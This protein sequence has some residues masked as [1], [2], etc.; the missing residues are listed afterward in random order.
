[1]MT[2][3]WALGL[4]VPEDLPIICFSD[5]MLDDFFMYIHT[6][7]IPYR[8]MASVATEMLM[9]KLAD[10]STPLP[11][12]RVPFSLLEGETFRPL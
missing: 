2:A 12:R 1:M 6:Y 8:E 5:G 10:F 4:R 9:I 7:V 11:A 3:A